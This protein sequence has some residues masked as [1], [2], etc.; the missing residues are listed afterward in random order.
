MDCQWYHSHKQMNLHTMVSTY[1]KICIQG[2]A[3]SQQLKT[4]YLTICQKMTWSRDNQKFE[5][6]NQDI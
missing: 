5:I 4:T 3:Q 2:Q 1:G 6:H